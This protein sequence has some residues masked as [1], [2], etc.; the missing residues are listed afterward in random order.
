V[1]VI[2]YNIEDFNAPL[3]N[4][5]VSPQGDDHRVPV[6]RLVWAAATIGAAH[7]GPRLR[8][9]PAALSCNGVRQ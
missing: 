9:R 5:L 6:G 7:F 3:P 2:Y 4:G 8:Q 1:A